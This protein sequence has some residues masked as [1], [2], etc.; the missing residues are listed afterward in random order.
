MGRYMVAPG[1]SVTTKTG[2]ISE[3]RTIAP[4]DVGSKAIF[5]AMIRCGTIHDKTVKIPRRSTMFREPAHNMNKVQAPARAEI[6]DIKIISSKF[7]PDKTTEEIENELMPPEEAVEEV[8]VVED[9]EPTEEVEEAI[10]ET[11][12][13]EE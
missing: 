5:D 11:E 2:T 10:E 3:F 4:R 12:E 8:K 7:S 6:K 13:V 1:K 9:A